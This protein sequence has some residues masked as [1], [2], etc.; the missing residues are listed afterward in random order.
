MSQP[1]DFENL[2]E[3]GLIA[4]LFGKPKAGGVKGCSPTNLRKFRQLYRALPGI[5]RDTTDGVC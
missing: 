2:V 3:R 5:P 4:S 1:V